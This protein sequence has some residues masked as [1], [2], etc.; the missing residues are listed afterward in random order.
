MTE[1]AQYGV[2]ER[3]FTAQAEK[4][5]TQSFRA[6]FT[7]PDGKK[8]KVRGFYDGE[9]QYVLRFMPE[10]PGEYR[11]RTESSC[12]ALH[13]QSGTFR[14]L[15]SGRHGRVVPSGLYLEHADGTRHFSA[16]TTCY[17]WIYQPEHVREETLREL[18]NGWFNKLRM[19]VFPKRYLYNEEEPE[20]YPFEG[21]PGHFDY[22]RPNVKLF[23]RLDAMVERL[24]AMGIQADII[25]FH[26][27]DD[28]RWGFSDMSAE[29][30]RRYIRYVTAR[31]AAYEN[32]W[33]SAANEYDLF[34]KG[35]KAKT[36][37]WDGI[38]RCI[39]ESDPFGHML[40]IHQCF[41]VYDHRH[42]AVTHC[43]LQRTGMYVST[44]TTGRFQEK[45]KKPVVWDEI[46][47]EGDIKPTFGSCTPQELTR[48]F[49][50][51]AIRGASAGHG[52]TYDS[53][54]RI[55]WWSKG[56]TLRGESPQRIR[57][58]REIMQDYGCPRFSCCQNEEQL[59]AGQEEDKVLAWYFGNTQSRKQD[60]V[61]PQR[62]GY[63]LEV[64]DTW[65]MTRCVLDGLHR[66]VTEVELGQKPYMAVFARKEE[67]EPLPERF[68]AD[69]L[70]R[71]MRSY[72][73]GKTFYRLM[74]LAPT[75][76][77]NAFVFNESFGHLQTLAPGVVTDRMIEEVCGYIN[78]GRLGHLLRLLKKERCRP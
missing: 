65:N 10:K 44:E 53:P 38:L 22:D 28:E 3:R 17:A 40:G 77:K 4:P 76:R 51:A 30:D 61:L 46:N 64:I 2:F 63:R 37:S 60:L 12:P 13:G 70:L 52:E 8:T 71:E 58:L 34:R 19:C 6:V 29:Q 23:Q 42:S 39:R 59:P 67:A 49:W 68:D 21:T 33:W 56:G 73:G 5:F 45:Y 55:L 20:L 72:K 74:T 9:D 11:F 78:D 15:P 62:N 54:D 24:G 14:C 69:C 35:Y 43:S 26:P 16:G 31:L 66:G 50:E 32:V 47:Y 41:R 1:I 18:A 27:Y 75:V 25:L 36:K 48:H 57:F 7:G